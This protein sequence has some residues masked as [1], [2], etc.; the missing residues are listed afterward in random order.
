MKD[1]LFMYCVEYPLT[2]GMLSLLNSVRRLRLQESKLTFVTRGDALRLPG[3]LLRLQ[4]DP[5]LFQ[6]EPVQLPGGLILPQGE[7]EPLG[8]DL[9]QYA[10]KVRILN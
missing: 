1:L 2:N 10:S 8:C 5:L 7:L 3:E 6:V 9:L 4:I